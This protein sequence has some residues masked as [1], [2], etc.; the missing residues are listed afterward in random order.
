MKIKVGVVEVGGSSGWSSDVAVEG[1]MK[2]GN[3]VI[4]IYWRCVG[5]RWLGGGNWGYGWE[6]C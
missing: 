6:S 4:I 1:S 3:V 5:Y 2:R